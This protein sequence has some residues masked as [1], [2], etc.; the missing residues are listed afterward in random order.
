MAV[1]LLRPIPVEVGHRLEALEA[2]SGAAA[3]ESAPRAIL[4]F[5]ID[6]MLD[7]LEM[8]PALFRGG[9]DQVVEIGGRNEQAERAESVFDVGHRLCSGSMSKDWSPSSS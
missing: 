8:T 2:T 9:G 5:D 3:L 6:D 7:E 1:D 4:L